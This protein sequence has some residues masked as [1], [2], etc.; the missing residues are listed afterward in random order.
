[1]SKLLLDVRERE[2]DVLVFEVIEPDFMSKTLKFTLSVKPEQVL[3]TDKFVLMG[4]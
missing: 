4:H 2:I 1:M 3:N